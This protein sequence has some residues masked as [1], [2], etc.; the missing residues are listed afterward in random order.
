M[1][2]AI[3]STGGQ[4]GR[5]HLADGVLVHLT[6]SLTG[7]HLPELRAALLSPFEETCRDVVVD[8]G[9]VGDAADSALAVLV[10]AKDWAQQH[11]RRFVLSRCSPALDVMLTEIGAEMPRL[12]P[13]AQRVARPRVP[14][15]RGAAD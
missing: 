10:A 6:G 13:L 8:A 15:P 14:S 11:G 2:T 12:E 7:E 1:T 4:V 3:V 5:M 9:E